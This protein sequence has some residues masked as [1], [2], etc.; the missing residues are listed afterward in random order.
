[1]NPPEGAAAPA[2]KKAAWFPVN[3]AEARIVITGFFLLFCVLGGYFAVRPVRETIGTVLGREA[4]QNLWF[5]TALFAILIVPFYGWLVAHVRR[6][7]LLPAIYGFMS[8]AF[9]GAAQIFGG[10]ALD[11]MVARVF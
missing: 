11:P 6:S 7:V 5:F 8:L 10:S 2:N 1:M 9:V 4:T 3:G